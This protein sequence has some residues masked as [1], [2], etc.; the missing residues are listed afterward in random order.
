LYGK[1]QTKKN[2]KRIRFTDKSKDSFSARKIKAS[3]RSGTN[4]A[5]QMDT[6]AFPMKATAIRDPDDRFAQGGQR[7]RSLAVLARLVP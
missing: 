3:A 5:C 6:E 4:Q 7:E 2:S 1:R